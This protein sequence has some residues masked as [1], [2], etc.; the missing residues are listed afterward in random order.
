MFSHYINEGKKL[1]DFVEK[2]IN[3]E[4]VGVVPVRI[5]EG[6]LFAQDGRK[7]EVKAYQYQI[8]ILEI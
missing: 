6:Y 2:Q 5:D 4:P 3:I 7:A 8:T 1:Y